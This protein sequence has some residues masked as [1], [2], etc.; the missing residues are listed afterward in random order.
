MKAKCHVV[1]AAIDATGKKVHE[2]VRLYAEG[3]DPN[4]HTI[5]VPPAEFGTYVE[6]D[7]YDVPD[8]VDSIVIDE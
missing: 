2:E 8:P 4:G 3:L 7:E 1:A 5:I 6:G